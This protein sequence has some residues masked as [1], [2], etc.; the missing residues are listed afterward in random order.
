MELFLPHPDIS[1]ISVVN[2]Q[3]LQTTSSKELKQV[4]ERGKALSPKKNGSDFLPY[5]VL[6][7][8]HAEI[9]PEVMSDLS[10]GIHIFM[11]YSIGFI[12]SRYRIFRALHYLV[13]ES[14]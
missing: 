13:A 9:G 10:S 14:F 11:A 1:I 2:F 12:P 6:S 5:N 8:T 4:A 7:S 3:L